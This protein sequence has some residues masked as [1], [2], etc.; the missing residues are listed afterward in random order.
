MEDEVRRAVLEG[1]YDRIRQRLK[2]KDVTAEH[3]RAVALHA[4]GRARV[5]MELDPSW[6]AEELTRLQNAPEPKREP[7]P[8]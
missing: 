1:A 3:L 7:E 5:Q 4:L 2:A 6:V 8:E